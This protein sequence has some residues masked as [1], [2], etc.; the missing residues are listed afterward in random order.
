LREGG[1]LRQFLGQRG[2]RRVRFPKQLGFG[3]DAFA[4]HGAGLAPRL[5]EF[6]GLPQGPRL[7]GES[8]RHPLAMFG[9]DARHRRQ[10]SHGDLR[11]DPAFPHLLLDRFRQQFH[12]R[13]AA[14]HPRGAAIEAPR[15]FR[16]RAAQP[17]FHL[18][19]QPALFQRG[20]RLAHA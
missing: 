12:Q 3:Q 10:E 8:L 7:L 2:G 1:D 14:C 20:L 11:G 6:S 9:V 15:Q 4:H 16:D 19:Q 18:R 13:Q 17:A 5:V